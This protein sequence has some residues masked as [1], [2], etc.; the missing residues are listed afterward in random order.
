M[1]ARLL[2]NNIVPILLMNVLKCLSGQMPFLL[3]SLRFFF[4]EVHT[5]YVSVPRGFHHF[6]LFLADQVEVL[7]DLNVTLRSTGAHARSHF[8]FLNG[9]SLKERVYLLIVYS[10]R[11]PCIAI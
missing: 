11:D 3:S 4:W 5:F 1:C 7:S 6:I 8:Y 2:I 10:P 9:I